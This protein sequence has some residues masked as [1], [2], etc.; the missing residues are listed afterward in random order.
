MNVVIYMPT[1][2]NYINVFNKKVAFI[3]NEKIIS[4]M[5]DLNKQSTSNEKIINRCLADKRCN[6]LSNG[7]VQLW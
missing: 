4:Y 5:K 2:D 6:D 3:H 7:Y 1:E